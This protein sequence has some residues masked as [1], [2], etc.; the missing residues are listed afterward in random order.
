AE[1]KYLESKLALC[2]KT[3]YVLEKGL[4]LL[5]IKTLEEM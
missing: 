4:N 5:G 2:K 1:G 3:A